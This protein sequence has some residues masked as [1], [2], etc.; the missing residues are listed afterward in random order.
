MKEAM[1]FDFLITVKDS[2]LTKGRGKM[3]INQGTLIVP[4]RGIYFFRDLPWRI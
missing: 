3:M 1:H 2:V 4:G